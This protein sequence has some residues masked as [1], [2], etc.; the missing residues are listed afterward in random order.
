MLRIRRAQYVV[1]D[2]ASETSDMAP[3][4]NRAAKRERQDVTTFVA[5]R[6]SE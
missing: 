5:S 6:V 3:R 1:R 4:R 2:E